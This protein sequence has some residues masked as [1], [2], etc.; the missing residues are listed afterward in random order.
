MHTH[1][2]GES[3]V[4][5]KAAVCDASRLWWTLPANP[6]KLGKRQGMDSLVQPSHP[7]ERLL[8]FLP[9]ITEKTDLCCLSHSVC[10]TLLWQST[11]TVW[12]LVALLPLVPWTT[13][14]FHGCLPPLLPAAEALWYS[15]AG[16]LALSNLLPSHWAWVFLPPSLNRNCY[17][18]HSKLLFAMKAVVLHL[19]YLKF[20]SL[21]FLRLP[22]L[23]HLQSLRFLEGL[24]YSQHPPAPCHNHTIQRDSK[25]VM[26]IGSRA[27]LPGLRAELDIQKQY[28]LGKFIDLCKPWFPDLQNS[29]TL[30]TMPNT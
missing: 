2:Q 14:G 28:H 20:K 22:P 9:S 6:Q 8:G 15:S 18:S 30:Q 16:F 12:P 1:T 5:R 7:F 25:V 21:S 23:F 3:Y 26:R 4:K 27:R 19:S 10:S 13:L 11:P 29:G 24:H 17:F